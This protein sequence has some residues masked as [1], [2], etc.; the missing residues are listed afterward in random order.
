[1]VVKRQFNMLDLLADIDSVLIILQQKGWL[2]ESLSTFWKVHIPPHFIVSTH[3]QV[4]GTYLLHQVGEYP[5][6]HNTNHYTQKTMCAISSLCHLEVQVGSTYNSRS[7]R[8]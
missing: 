4:F 3:N 1:M 8:W 5:N 2:F 7:R 6:T